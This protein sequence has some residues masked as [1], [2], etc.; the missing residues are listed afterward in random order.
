[1]TQKIFITGG[2]GCIGHYL[3][4]S[5]LDKTDWHLYLLL[6]NPQKLKV[7]Y[8]SHRVT[9]L[10][11]G[12]QDIQEHRAIVEQMDYLVSTAACWGG[13]DTYLI[14]V[15]KTHALFSY[16][17]PDICQRAI[18]FSTAS[19]LDQHKN[20]LPEAGAIGT[21]YIR[22]KYWGLQ[23][24]E[25]LPISSKL[26][27]V[28]PTIVFGGN[29][30][31]KPF[32]FISAGLQDVLKYMPYI[33]WLKTEGSFHFIH[34][35]DIAQIVTQLLL[36]GYPNNSDTPLRLVMGMPQISVNQ[37]IAEICEFT[38]HRI[39]WQI[40]LTPALINL[41]RWLFR[42]QMGEWDEF[43]LKQRHFVYN[44]ITPES[45]GLTAKYPRLTD[46]LTDA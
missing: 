34:A 5:L 30:Q 42:L 15:E 23:E 7:N 17:N 27:T 46:L 39:W 20:L 43:C 3:V 41:V 38:Q 4:E 29:G 24:L 2:S 21:D 35:F 45:L 6:R 19:I 1:M 8:S 26:I 16:L 13:E 28:F 32:S 22:S 11:G 25:N 9:I 33:R 31:D 14:N 18:Y 37:A 10:Q 36:K 12:L 40:E 44:H